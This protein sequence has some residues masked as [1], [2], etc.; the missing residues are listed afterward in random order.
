MDYINLSAIVLSNSIPGNL[1]N[2]HYFRLWTINFTNDLDIVT[3]KYLDNINV[4]DEVQDQ[5]FQFQVEHC[6]VFICNTCK[7]IK[8]KDKKAALKQL[9]M[10]SKLKYALLI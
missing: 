6:S 9:I 4:M 1:S 8:I 7:K 2:L 3:N 5:S 10:F